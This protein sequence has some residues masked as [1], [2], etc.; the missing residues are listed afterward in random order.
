MNYTVET[1]AIGGWATHSTHGTLENA[2]DQS[3]LVHGRVIPDTHC[4]SCHAWRTLSV[5]IEEVVDDTA[6]CECQ[7]CGSF[8]TLIE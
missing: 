1:R 3:D 6:V 2:I 5:V 7:R 4:Q 8:V